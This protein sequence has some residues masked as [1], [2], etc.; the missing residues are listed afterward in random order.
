MGKSVQRT[1][2]VSITYSRQSAQ[3]KKETENLLK[4][5]EEELQLENLSKMREPYHI[6]ERINFC[7]N[8]PHYGKSRV[9][10]Y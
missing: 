3:I 6:L 7:E 8:N 10:L 2:P 5:L 9:R 1:I 4:E